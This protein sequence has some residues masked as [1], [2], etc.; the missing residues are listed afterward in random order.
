MQ[1]EFSFQLLQR[2][3]TVNA[4]ALE[5]LKTSK[6]FVSPRR[7]LPVGTPLVE[8]ISIGT[9]DK[10]QAAVVLE[11][12]VEEV[13]RQTTYDHSILHSHFAHFVYTQI[14]GVARH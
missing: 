9:R 1:P 2:F 5:S 11:A 8:L 7:T 12:L 6:E 13:S 14:P 3:L 10:T 4:A